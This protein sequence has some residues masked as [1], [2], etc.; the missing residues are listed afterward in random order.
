MTRFKAVLWRGRIIHSTW[1][2][3][4]VIISRRHDRYGKPYLLFSRKSSHICI[5][6]KEWVEFKTSGDVLAQGN[7]H[8]LSKEKKM[9]PE[10]LNGGILFG[11]NKKTVI[12]LRRTAGLS[13][14][15][16]KPGEYRKVADYL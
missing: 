16:V 7:E 8:V 4:H 15:Y 10:V 14:H 3:S 11:L 13:A 5:F 2:T 9:K 1:K 6:M 12:N